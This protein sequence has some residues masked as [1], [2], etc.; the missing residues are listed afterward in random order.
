MPSPV[1]KRSEPLLAEDE[2][3]DHFLELPG[4][5]D[6]EQTGS[7]AVDLEP[8]LALED[9]LELVPRGSGK[10]VPPVV[11]AFAPVLD[12]G[13]VGRAASG[14][15]RERD[16]RENGSRAH[17]VAGFGLRI[18]DAMSPASIPVPTVHTHTQ[19]TSWAPTA[20]NRNFWVVDIVAMS[21]GKAS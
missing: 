9:L 2:V 8:A 11:L 10:G 18:F 15:R 1:S 14:G 3:G 13:V 19:M 4:L 20:P 21:G 17:A 12:E 5:V 6:G 7:D 16:R